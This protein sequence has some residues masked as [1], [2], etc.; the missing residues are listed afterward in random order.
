MPAIFLGAFIWAH[1]FAINELVGC[2]AAELRIRNR[3]SSLAG[4]GDI[5][6]TIPAQARA[7]NYEY[8]N[9]DGTTGDANSFGYG[10]PAQTQAH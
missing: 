2:I 1:P 6:G 9:N 7:R 8:S 5:G 4:A 3:H 10:Y